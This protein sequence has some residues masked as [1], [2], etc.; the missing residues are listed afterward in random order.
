MKP[1]LLRSDTEY[2][3]SSKYAASSFT[4]TLLMCVFY[5]S[6]FSF[7]HILLTQEDFLK[8]PAHLQQSEILRQLAQNVNFNRRQT[9]HCFG[10]AR[11]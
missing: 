6:V 5:I 10:R 3:A 2:M 8:H 1:I 9:P 11:D 4:S 7:T